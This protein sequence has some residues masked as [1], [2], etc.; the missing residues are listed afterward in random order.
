MTRLS[1]RGETIVEVLVVMAVLSS[2]LGSA[3]ALSSKT[4]NVNRESQERSRAVGYA[5]NQLERLKGVVDQSNSTTPN[6][7]CF[8]NAGV[9]VPILPANYAGVGNASPDADDFTK[10]PTECID[11]LFHAVIVYDS[12]LAPTNGTKTYT[13]YVRWDKIGQ[14]GHNNVVLKYRTEYVRDGTGTPPAVSDAEVAPIIADPCAAVVVN[15]FRA[16]YFSGTSPGARLITITGFSPGTQS[17]PINNNWPGSPGAGVSADDF[18]ARWTGTFVFDPAVYTFTFTSK[19]GSRLFIDSGIELVGVPTTPASWSDHAEQTYTVTRNMSAG[20]HTVKF[21]FYNSTGTAIAG[22]SWEKTLQ[23]PRTGLNWINN[24]PNNSSASAAAL[25]GKNNCTQV[26]ETSDPSGWLNNYLCTNDALSLTWSQAN[27][28]SGRYCTRF[29]TPD[30][31]SW[32]DNWL[33]APTD[34]G[35][36]FRTDGVTPAGQSCIPITEPMDTHALGWNN[37]NFRLCETNA[38]AASSFPWPETMAGNGAVYKT[39]T[40]GAFSR[41]AVSYGSNSA[42]GVY[43]HII[44]RVNGGVVFDGFVTGSGT[45]SV[46]GLSYPAGTYNIS[47]EFD[48]DVCGPPCD[49]NNPDRNL[50]LQG[51]EFTLN[52]PIASIA[53]PSNYTVIDPRRKYS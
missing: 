27:A 36:S 1:S 21:E 29:L 41:L 53:K 40:T 7:F 47:V 11:G 3:F 43:P 8:S 16:C 35:L 49:G 34:L 50:Y 4:I 20:P 48:N 31:N 39:V 19:D 32:N 6:K 42:Y 45:T 10:Y 24:G 5:Q 2:V 14:T 46:T 23:L 51:V 15:S 37:G 38:P 13:S 9:I 44:V 22:L 33:C 12:P 26:Y 28:I 17:Y 52:A 30:S 25:I 18:S